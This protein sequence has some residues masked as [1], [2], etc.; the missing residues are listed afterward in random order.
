MKNMIKEKYEVKRVLHKQICMKSRV[1]ELNSH[2]AL[3][4]NCFLFLILV[5]YDYNVFLLTNYT[6]KVVNKHKTFFTLHIHHCV[7]NV[8]KY[9]F[10]KCFLKPV[11]SATTHKKLIEIKRITSTVTYFF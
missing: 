3:N 10:T 1:T 8:I 4:C 11:H 9:A 7:H 6:C 2:C 5:R